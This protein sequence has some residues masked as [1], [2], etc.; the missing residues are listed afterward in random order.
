GFNHFEPTYCVSTGISRQIRDEGGL[1]IFFSDFITARRKKCKHDLSLRP[2]CFQSLHN[3]SCL[4]K[5]A[6][7]CYM[8]PDSERGFFLK[9][10]FFLI[11]LLSAFNPFGCFFIPHSCNAVTCNHETYKEMINGPDHRTRRREKRL[12]ISD[13]GLPFAADGNNIGSSDANEGIET[14]SIEITAGGIVEV[15]SRFGESAN[16]VTQNIEVGIILRMLIL[17]SQG[18][19][20][21]RTICQPVISILI[22]IVE[23]YD[24]VELVLYSDLVL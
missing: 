14:I 23:R 2:Q 24:I 12:I 1:S 9:S 13:F 8:K 15:T 17:K 3:W 11:E 21:G 19:L 10:N 6:K 5:L 18:D 22:F 20:N 7:A 4:F 16:P